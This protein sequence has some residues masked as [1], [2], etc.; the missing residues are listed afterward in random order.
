MD[1]VDVVDPGSAALFDV[2]GP[3]DGTLPASSADGGES[4]GR[5]GVAAVL[6]DMDGL[7][8][9]TEPLWTV[10]EHELAASLGARFTPEIKAAMIGHGV[11]TALPLMLSML[12]VPDADPHAA[13]RFL[14][15]RT[16]ELF[17]EP[18][19]IVPMPGAVALL[20]VLAAAGIA[21]ALVSSSFR[22]LMDPVLAAV[23]ADRF[24]VT[25]AGDEVSRRKPHPEPYLTAARLLGADP[26]RCVV[27]ED[28]EAGARA[29]LD[30]GCP[31]ILVPSIPAVVAP[32]LA[33]QVTVRPSLHEVTLDLLD[34]LATQAGVQSR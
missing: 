14:I 34:I 25:V 30:A 18:E 5:S 23:G 8:V 4:R 17:G 9:D 28:S 10:A 33:A 11:D 31:T 26:A 29:G 19:R 22:V 32:P 16:A 2:H 6:F 20:D 15:E 12:G 24:A 7:L 27:L 13:A 3:D 1:P 21:T